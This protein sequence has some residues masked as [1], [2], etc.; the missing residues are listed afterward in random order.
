MPGSTSLLTWMRAPEGSVIGQENCEGWWRVGAEEKTG[1]G[2][3][4]EAEQGGRQAEGKCEVTG[5]RERRGSGSEGRRG[6]GWTIRS[7]RREGRDAEAARSP[8]LTSPA[9][10]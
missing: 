4:K 2:A 5:K 6:N 1:E 9:S 7:R 3:G 10:T 8:R